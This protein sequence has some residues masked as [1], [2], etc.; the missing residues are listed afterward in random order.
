MGVS[1]PP[2]V[3]WYEPDVPTVPKVACPGS[4]S[5]NVALV[6]V[7]GPHLQSVERHISIFRQVKDV[8]PIGRSET[9]QL[10]TGLS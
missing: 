9:T 6:L 3:V 8:Y 4:P 1:T 5:P 2:R 7:G 10:L